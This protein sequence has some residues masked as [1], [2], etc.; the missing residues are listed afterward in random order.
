MSRLCDVNCE[1]WFRIFPL[2]LLI[3][4]VALDVLIV[5]CEHIVVRGI[6]YLL[7]KSIS[8]TEH[9]TCLIYQYQF[10]SWALSQNCPPTGLSRERF[11]LVVAAKRYNFHGKGVAWQLKGIIG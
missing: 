3:D 1:S 11:I 5:L 9:G 8:R 10:F 4:S 2:E 6:R 7:A